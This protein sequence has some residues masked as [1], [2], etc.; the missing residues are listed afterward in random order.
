VRE[1]LGVTPPELAHPG[2]N[3]EGMLVPVHL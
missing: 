3:T 2:R 1:R